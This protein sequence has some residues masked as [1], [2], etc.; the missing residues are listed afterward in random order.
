MIIFGYFFGCAIVIIS[1]Y[2]MQST[3]KN[4]IKF[5][6][7]SK[8]SFA[9]SAKVFIA[10][11]QFVG[12]SFAQSSWRINAKRSMQE[13]PFCKYMFVLKFLRFSTARERSEKMKRRKSRCTNDRSYRFDVKSNDENLF[14]F[15]FLLFPS[16]FFAIFCGRVQIIECCF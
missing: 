10:K 8:F 3:L 6:K 13:T 11:F 1:P 14:F 16:I 5:R 12:A 2:I 4:A 9:C 7:R 15:F